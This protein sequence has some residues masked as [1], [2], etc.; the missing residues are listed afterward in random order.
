MKNQEKND[1]HAVVV[2][3]E[4]FED[5]VLASEK[6]VI[7]DFWADWCGPCHVLSPIVE[8]IAEELADKLIVAKVN[9]DENPT[10]A[11]RFGILAMPTLT[12]FRDGKPI[13]SVVGARPKR[14]L[15]AEISKIL[16]L[17]DITD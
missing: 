12:V 15:L 10:T 14:R 8:E 17:P 11:Q 7:V 3:D 16:D 13:S 6:P 1:R 9:V 2:T 4:S 5:V